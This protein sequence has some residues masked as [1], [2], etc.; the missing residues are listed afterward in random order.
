MLV[1]VEK[2]AQ[3]NQRIT[4]RCRFA[5]QSEGLSWHKLVLANAGSCVQRG[6]LEVG[7]ACKPISDAVGKD[8]VCLGLTQLLSTVKLC[9]IEASKLS[10]DKQVMPKE[11]AQRGGSSNTWT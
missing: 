2:L 4:V 7:P 9:L 11:P 10:L 5:Y 3:C 8:P 6:R 1:A